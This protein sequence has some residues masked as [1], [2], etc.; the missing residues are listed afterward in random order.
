[1]ICVSDFILQDDF[2]QFQILSRS[3]LLPYFV[4]D[5]SKKRFRHAEGQIMIRIL[6]PEANVTNVLLFLSERK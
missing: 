1:M 5:V 4:T 6:D 2:D 3:T